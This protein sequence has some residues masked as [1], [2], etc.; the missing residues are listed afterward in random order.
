MQ[1]NYKKYSIK[2]KELRKRV[3]DSSFKELISS[4]IKNFSE[5]STELK[6]KIK[7]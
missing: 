1:Y 7:H 2:L 6:K 5:V 4:T 3:N